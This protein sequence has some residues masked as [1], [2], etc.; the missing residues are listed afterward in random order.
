[1]TSVLEYFCTGCGWFARLGEFLIGLIYFVSSRLVLIGG[2]VFFVRFVFCF[3]LR[4]YLVLFK[5][6]A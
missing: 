5:L 1:M 4:G 3:K 2:W 6:R